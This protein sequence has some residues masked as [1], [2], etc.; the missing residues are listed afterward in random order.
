MLTQARLQGYPRPT[1][2]MQTKQ[3][4]RAA[5]SLRALRQATGRSAPS[6]GLAT[7]IEPIQ[8]VGV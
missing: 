8:K 3:Y 1:L 7:S 6:R 2:T 4:M 5:R